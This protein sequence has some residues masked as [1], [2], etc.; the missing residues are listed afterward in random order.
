MTYK[1]RET[2]L[3]Q[4]YT[5]KEAA[6]DRE[7]LMQSIL[8]FEAIMRSAFLADA[9]MLGLDCIEGSEP[10]QMEQV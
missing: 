1:C 2:S 5:E 10:D 7:M 9:P 3:E 6:Q 8:E 4:V